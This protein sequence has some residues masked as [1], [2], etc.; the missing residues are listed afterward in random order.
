MSDKGLAPNYK[1]KELALKK[2]SSIRNTVGLVTKQTYRD[3]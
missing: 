2:E 3:K 1:G